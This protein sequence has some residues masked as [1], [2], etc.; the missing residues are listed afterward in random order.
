MP[1]LV[2]LYRTF[3][4][5]LASFAAQAAGDGWP[6]RRALE[7]RLVTLFRKALSEPTAVFVYLALTALDL[8]QLRSELVQ[9]A[10]FVPRLTTRAAP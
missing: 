8:E 6:L 10:I 1:L 9:R 3:G 4:S 5:H 7:K 2:E